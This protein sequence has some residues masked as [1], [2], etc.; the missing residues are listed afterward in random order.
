MTFS[1]R[2][3][4]AIYCS[5][6]YSYTIHFSGN[7]IIQPEPLTTDIAAIKTPT[8]NPY[9]IFPDFSHTYTPLALFHWHSNREVQ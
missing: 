5:P 9:I 4:V 6:V 2:I 3:L 8:T 7:H 1:D